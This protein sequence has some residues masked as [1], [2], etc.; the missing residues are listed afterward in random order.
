VIEL[1]R[2]LATFVI[3][4]FNQE[5]VVTDAIE[6]A[7]A[8]TYSPLEIILSDDCSS[9]DTFNVMERAAAEYKGPHRIVLNRNS[10]NLNIGGHVNAVAKL[11][12]GDLIVLAGGDDIS[13]PL[14]TERLVQRWIKLGCPPAVLYSDFIPMDRQSRLVNLHHEQI[15][16][17]IH[18]KQAM[19]AGRIWVL[20]ATTAVSK[21]VFS[22]LPPFDSSVR[23]DDRIHPFRALLLD[24]TVSLVDEKLVRYRI[25]GG[26]SRGR[27][28]S[29]YDYVFNYLPAQ[30]ARTLPD[31]KQRLAD[32]DAVVPVDFMLRQF[33][34][35]TIAYHEAC[36]EL[37]GKRGLGVEAAL[38]KWLHYGAPPS[39]LL[40]VYLKRRFHQ[41]F[42]LYF[43]YQHI[44]RLK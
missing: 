41:I 31:A 9:D 42:D 13:L 29:G 23:H 44:R 37:V 7:F 33:C 35:A 26:I 21:Q 39:A 5:Q 17:G 27:A 14:R 22:A 4:A 10:H 43:Y 28:M 6:A 12:S 18:C 36:I 38:L 20:G 2:P 16:R 30:L 34:L 40:K 1:K 25:E 3:F 24:G 11:A 15:Y 32:L 19:A 8:Q